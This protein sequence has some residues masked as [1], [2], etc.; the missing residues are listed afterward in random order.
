MEETQILIRAHLKLPPCSR[1]GNK[2][3][4]DEVKIKL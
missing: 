2:H 4:L 3:G 1:R